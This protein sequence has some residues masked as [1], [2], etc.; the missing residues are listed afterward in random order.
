VSHA[1]TRGRRFGAEETARLERY[2]AERAVG[3]LSYFLRAFVWPVVEPAT[4]YHHGWN[5]DAVC[6]HLEAVTAGD[7]NRLI[8]NVPPRTLKS[9]ITSVAW[10]PWEWLS[11]PS[12][13]WLFASYGERL[14]VRDSLKTR[15]VVQARMYRRAVAILHDLDPDSYTAWDLAGDQNAKT[16]FETSAAGFRIATSVGGMATGEG[17]DR[18]VAD[19]ALNAQEAVSDAALEACIEWW[20]GAMSTRLNDPENGARVIIMQRLHERDLTGHVLEKGTGYTHLCL[21]MRFEEGHPHVWRGGRV[22]EPVAA[23]LAA[24][25]KTRHLVD[26]DPREEGELVNARISEER[27]TELEKDLGPVRA[28]GQFQQRPAPADGIIFK[29]AWWRYYVTPEWADTYGIPDDLPTVVCPR[30]FEEELLSVDAS[31]KDEEVA[32]GAPDYVVMQAWARK[33]SWKYLIEQRRGMWGF[34]TTVAQLLELAE[35]NPNAYLK[36]IEDKANGPAIIDTLRG[37]VGGILGI[38]PEGGKVARA[39]AISSQ[40]EAGE[41]FLPHPIMCAWTEGYVLEHTTF[42]N[43][44]H[45]DQVDCTSQALKRLMHGGAS[46]GGPDLWE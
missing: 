42:P 32:K 4:R 7:I 23:R 41:V 40:V 9:T 3:S 15:R 10:T 6:A 45:D 35:S 36:L 28:A 31:F 20:D 38:E 21:P 27:V 24:E 14:S 39:N 37:K 8:I 16:R 29:A 43:G 2:R 26:G 30:S 17:G 44:A 18:I 5:I 34:T 11:N 46:S 12:T 19:D 22:A 13:R 1:A 33:G 25:P